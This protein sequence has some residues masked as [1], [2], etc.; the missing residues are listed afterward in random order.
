MFIAENQR[1]EASDSASGP[2]SDLYG[3][4][5]GGVQGGVRH[6]LAAHAAG[7]HQQDVDLQLRLVLLRQYGPSTPLICNM[8]RLPPYYMQYGRLPHF[9]RIKL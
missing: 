8:A 1:F 5:A 4:S 6:S 3:A 2:S 7:S 9:L